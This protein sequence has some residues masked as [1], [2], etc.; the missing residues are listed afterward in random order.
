MRSVIR[1]HSSRGVVLLTQVLRRVVSPT[2]CCGA[3]QHPPIERLAAINQKAI[4]FYASHGI[5]L[6]KEPLEVAVCAQHSNGGLLIDAWWRTSVQGLYAAGECAGAFGMYRPGGSAL[7]E[8]QVGS[9]RA[10][11][12]IIHHGGLEKNESEEAFLNAAQGDIA[13]ETAY[14][15]RT[16]SDARAARVLSQVRADMDAYAGAMRDLD[17]MREMLARVQAYL[18]EGIAGST[19]EETAE[20]R[21]TLL[22]QRAAL[23]AMLCQAQ[24]SGEAGHGFVRR[25]VAKDAPDA[26]NF[27][28]ETRGMETRAVALR[29]LPQGGGWFET[30][31]RRYLNDE[32][33]G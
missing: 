30:V 32:V 11:M 6:H 23:S 10:A 4:D 29:P 14:F 17:K 9:L 16:A 33:Y 24:F 18:D 1:H 28:F 2:C 15:S 7:N 26:K 5:D 12:Y 31:W 22:V 13:R 27:A 20:L 19:P 8:T 3:A 25:S 21:D